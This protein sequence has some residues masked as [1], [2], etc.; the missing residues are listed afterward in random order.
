M[1][2]DRRFDERWKSVIIP[3]VQRITVDGSN[4]EPYRVDAIK[5]SDSILTEILTGI[6]NCRLFFAD[7]TTIGQVEEN[8]IRNGNVM[9]ELGLAQAV[10][11]PEEAVLF[12][13]DRDPLPFDVASIRVHLY[14]PENDPEAAREQVHHILNT[15]LDEID[16]QKS[17]AVRRAGDCLDFNS[18]I[19]LR[20]TIVDNEMKHPWAPNTGHKLSRTDRMTAIYRLLDLGI[21]STKYTSLKLNLATFRTQPSGKEIIEY[22]ITSFGKAVHKLVLDRLGAQSE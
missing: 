6:S 20:K 11:L 2:F 18:W 7:I 17:L 3:A 5:V 13:S 4:L 22:E 8:P 14:E 16:L 19:V 9:Y 21:L 12:R 1:S 10:R 15:C